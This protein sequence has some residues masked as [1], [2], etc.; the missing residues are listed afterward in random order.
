MRDKD[1]QLK[2]QTVEKQKIIQRCNVKIQEEADKMIQE[3]ER[4]LQEQRERMTV[5]FRFLKLMFFFQ[6]IS[7]EIASLTHT[8]KSELISE[9]Y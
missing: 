3:M 9:L 6:F 5:Y 2:Q 1:R 8:M 4:K 7:P